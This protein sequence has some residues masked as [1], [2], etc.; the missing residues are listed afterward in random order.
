M[1]APNRLQERKVKMKEKKSKGHV[2]LAILII[3]ALERPEAPLALWDCSL[4]VWIFMCVRV[5]ER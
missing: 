4:R 5:S 1:I 3:T 2:P